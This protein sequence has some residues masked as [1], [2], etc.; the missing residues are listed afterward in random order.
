MVL[1]DLAGAE[2]F[3]SATLARE[4]L[5]RMAAAAPE[6]E[7]RATLAAWPRAI[8]AHETFERLRRSG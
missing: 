8:E 2:A 4:T 5:E 6:P 7:L 3:A 1:R